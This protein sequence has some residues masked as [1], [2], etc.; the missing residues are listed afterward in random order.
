M[1]RNSEERPEDQRPGRLPAMMSSGGN[2]IW[3][4]RVSKQPGVRLVLRASTDGNVWASIGGKTPRSRR[5]RGD[6]PPR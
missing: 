5:V 4:C 6:A 3:S 1:A 2:L